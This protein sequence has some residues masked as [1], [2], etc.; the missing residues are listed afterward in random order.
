MAMNGSAL[1]TVAERFHSLFIAVGLGKCI[2]PR[3]QLKQTHVQLYQLYFSRG[4]GYNKKFELSWEEKDG[5]IFNYLANT[6]S[7]G[8]DL[9]SC[10]LR[11]S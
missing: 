3:P 10:V 8:V 11:T 7:E 1:T 5:P 9:E 2:V 6:L 4:T